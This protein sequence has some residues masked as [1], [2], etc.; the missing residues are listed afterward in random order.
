MANPKD[1]LPQNVPGGY[2]VDSSCIDCDLCRDTA[3]GIFLRHDETAFS[4]VARQPRTPEEIERAEEARRNCPVEAIG[5][6]AEPP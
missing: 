2:Y 3:P 4:Y 5:N 6:D 1:R